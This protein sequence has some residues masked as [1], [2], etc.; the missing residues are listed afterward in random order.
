MDIRQALGQAIRLVRKQKGLTQE[1]FDEVSSRTYMSTLER[2]LKSPTID[3]LGE[4]AGVMGISPAALVCLAYA[5]QRQDNKTE[6]L[7][8]VALE[9][10]QFLEGP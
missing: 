7:E 3:K 4:I 5:I 8:E 10:R 2:G 6:L 9:V 1:E